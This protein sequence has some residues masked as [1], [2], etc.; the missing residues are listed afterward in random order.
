MWYKRFHTFCINIPNILAIIIGCIFYL[1]SGLI[2]NGNV[3]AKG[4]F[5][6]DEIKKMLCFSTTMTEYISVHSQFGNPPHVLLNNIHV[7]CKI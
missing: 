7:S 5:T 1:F 2:V 4:I 3:T 6:N